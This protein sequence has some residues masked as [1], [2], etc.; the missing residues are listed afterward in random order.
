MPEWLNGAVSK[1]VIH[2]SESRVRIPVSPLNQYQAKSKA[3][4]SYE[5]RLFAF[6]NTPNCSS[7]LKLLVSDPASALKM[8]N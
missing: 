4:N 6:K 2:A 7:K 5:F 8:Q 3:C 1:T